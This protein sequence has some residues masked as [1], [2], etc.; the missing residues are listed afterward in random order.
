MS[1][2]K[3][4]VRNLGADGQILGHNVHHSVVNLT[5]SC[6][7]SETHDVCDMQYG[8]DTWQQ[9]SWSYTG[10]GGVWSQMTV[11]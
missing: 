2:A 4:E 1:P 3:V 8:F 9:D 7:N 11:D 5:Q 10:N 6:T